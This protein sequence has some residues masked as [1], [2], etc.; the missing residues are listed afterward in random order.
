MQLP[1]Q[2]SL[3]SKPKP[4]TAFSSSPK[5]P[6]QTLSRPTLPLPSP[7]K[8]HLP[9]SSSSSQWFSL[10][11]QAISS[12]NLHLGKSI[13]ARILTSSEYPDRFLINNLITMYARCGSLLYARRMFDKMPD[14]DLISWNSILAAY[15]HSGEYD[16][17]NVKEG[18]CLFRLLRES[19]VLTSRLT[20]R[21]VLKLTLASGFVWASEAVHGYAVKIG[22]DWDVFFSGSLVNIYSKFGKIRE[23]RVLFDGMPERDVVL[24]NVMLQAYVQMGFEAETFHLFSNFHSSGLRPDDVS[25]RCV[26]SGISNVGSEVGKKHKEQVQAYAIKLFL[27]DDISNVVLSNKMLTGYLQVGDNCGVVECFADMIRSNVEYDSVTLA[28]ALTAVAGINNLKLGEQI[29]S[30][31]L[32]SGFNSAVSVGNSLISLYSKMGYIWFAKKVFSGMKELDLI[33]WNSMISSCSHSGLERESVNL[34]VDLLFHGLRP[35]HFTLASVLKACSSLTEGLYLSKQIHAH[36]T[37]AGNAADCFVSTALLDNYSRS[38]KMAEAECLFENK[39]EFD[40]ATWNA[41]MSGYISSNDSHKAL[42]LFTLMHMSGERSDEKTLATAVKACG[43]LLGLEQGKQIHA[44]VIKSGFESDLYVSS[45]ILDMYVKCGDMLDAHLVFNDISEPDDVAWTTMICGCVENGDE[46][47]A[48]SIYHQMRLSRV[49]PDEYT[50]PVLVK[51]SS[52]LT[53]LE[54]EDAYQLFKRMDANNIALWNAMLVGLAQHGNGEEALKLFKV[55]KTHGIAPDRVTF[56]GV[57]SACSHSGLVSEAYEYFHSMHENM[58]APLPTTWASSFN[59]AIIFEH[60]IGNSKASLKSKPKPTTVFSSSPKISYQTLSRPTLPLPSPGKT[61]LPSSSSS[62]QWFSLLRQA[63]SSSNLHL[64]KSIHARILTSSEY[65]DRFLINNLITMYA[66]CSSLLYARRVFDKMPDRN[67]I[68]WN[69]ILAAYAHSGE[70]DVENVKE[71]FCLFRLLRESVVLTS[72]LTLRPVLKLTLASGFV[73]ASEAVHGYAVK[74]GL[75][76]D[77]F[78]SGSLVNIYSKFGKIR[79][80]RVLFDGMP[81]RDV[82]LW[83]VMLQAFVEMGFEAET[84]HLFSNFH[85]SGL[86]PDDVS[87]RCVL[88]GISYVGSE[89]GKKHREQVQAYAIKL[90]LYD[91]ISNVVLLNKMLTEYLQVGDNCGVVECFANMIRS[92]VE[93][94]SVTLAV[95]LTA[96]AGINNLKLGEQI[97]SMALKS[98]F[99]SAVS[100]GNSLISMYSKMGYIWFSKKVFSGMKELDLISWNSMISSCSHSGLERESVNLFVD[101]LF[102]GLRPD[103]F[104]LASVLK[105]CSSLTEGLYLSKQIHAHVT[106]AGNAADCFVSTALLDNYSRSGKMAEAECLFE[107]KEEIDLATWNAMMSGYISSNDSHKA[108]KLF[109][110]MHMSGERSD[111]KT[112]TTAVK[113]C[114]CLSGLEQGKQIHAHVIKS[115]FDS[116]LYVSSG[117]LDMYVKCGDMLDAHLV[118]NDISEPDDVAWTTMICGCVENGDEERALSTYHRMRLSGVQPDEYTFP[119]LVKAS[120]SQHGNGEEALKLFKVM[121]THGIAPDRVT[122]IGVLSACSHSG[123][124]SEAYEYFHSMHEKYGIEPE[125][126]HYAYLVDALG[127]AGRT[128][129]AEELIATMPFEASASMYRALLG[130]CW[131]QGNTETGKRLAERLLALEPSDS[132]AYV[133]L[134]NIYAAANQWDDVSDARST[135]KRKYVKKD[136]GFSWI[137]VKNTLHL[138]VVDDKSHPQT[139]LIYDEV[140][141]LMKRIKE[142]GYIPDTDFVL[143]DVEEEEK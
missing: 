129:Q 58:T 142:E 4:T 2:A 49:Q 98:G 24:W 85:R 20:L 15:A 133:L 62:S 69:S 131:V 74:I 63:I 130:A 47:R 79:E 50:F 103:H 44:H 122:F 97:H 6:Y 9:S 51:A 55:M 67:L 14:R 82:V 36:V 46:E 18:F 13:H 16:V 32:K 70:Y 132:A 121:K 101:L 88:S 125:L 81:E 11:R 45:G 115:G 53:A 71:G 109:T 96:V 83:N 56:I 118:F 10:L 104:T 91:D 54:Q 39:E 21:P 52:C 120:S 59:D 43:C 64:G 93:Y 111:E 35:D 12:S 5:I 73:W 84:F 26:L 30:M 8:T 139:D 99:N 138:F 87:V 28:V 119:I 126:E 77:V 33:S 94:D 86:R 7:G 25:V 135:M 34:F 80:A 78:F 23:A 17:E 106:K 27:Y 112:L 114:G 66:R 116:D 3:K 113:A 108:L 29:H 31:A 95:V 42:K 60:D 41:M 89:V 110:L 48:L 136:P 134:S 127:R 92:N 137:D 140:E 124:V 65:P 72:R 90:F 57:L 100:V 68:S 19:V 102:H 1:M 61:H 40:L 76:W 105:A 38:G 75:D 107:N 143:L 128:Q 117:I 141:D 37:K 22:L 123:L